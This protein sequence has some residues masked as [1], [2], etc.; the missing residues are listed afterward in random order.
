MTKTKSKKVPAASKQA[1]KTGGKMV[2]APTAMSRTGPIRARE[3]AFK[4]YPDGRVTV[5]HRE[6]VAD[7][8]AETSVFQNV[9]FSINPGLRALFAWLFLIASRYESYSF[10]RLKF[11]YESMVSTS[12][13]GAVVMAVDFDAADTPPVSKA[14]LLSYQGAVRSNVW[15]SCEYVC[16]SANLQKLKQY[17]MRSTP[18]VSNLDVK[19]YDVGVLNIATTGIDLGVLSSLTVGELYVEYTVD[20]YTPQLSIDPS[21][22]SLAAAFTTTAED[23]PVAGLLPWAQ[24]AKTGLLPI[25]ITGAGGSL[26]ANRAGRYLI[27]LA[28]QGNHADGNDESGDI[29]LAPQDSLSTIENVDNNAMKGALE[30]ENVISGANWNLLKDYFW[31]VTAPGARIHFPDNLAGVTGASALL[32]AINTTVSILAPG[33]PVSLDL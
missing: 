3:A 8:V 10:R 9:Q 20:L 1:G 15:K 12:T 2:S 7:V 5:T 18:L 21:P 27:Q 17:F 4:S 24:S 11:I 25:A 22:A 6:Y 26:I 31:N 32:K 30:P 28:L 29:N 14:Q 23:G 33:I 16:T 19:T 13:A